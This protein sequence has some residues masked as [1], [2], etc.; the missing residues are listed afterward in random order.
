MTGYSSLAKER[1]S[2]RI[3]L[4]LVPTPSSPF[5][6]RP[7]SEVRPEIIIYDS[8]ILKRRSDL[9]GQ[10]S[11]GLPVQD[12]CSHQVQW[13]AKTHSKSKPLEQVYPHPLVHDAQSRNSQVGPPSRILD[14]ETRHPGCLSA[15]TG[16]PEVETVP[17]LLLLE[18]SLFLQR[19]TLRTYLGPIR[20]H[21]ADGTPFR[22]SEAGKPLGHRLPRR[23]GHLVILGSQ[24][25]GLC[26][27]CLPN[28]PTPGIHPEPREISS[29]PHSGFGLA[30]R[31][32]DNPRTYNGPSSLIC[33]ETIHSGLPTVLSCP[34][35]QKTIGD[36]A[37]TH[38]ICLPDPD[39]RQTELS[40]L[41]QD[42]SPKLG[43][44]QGPTTTVP[45][46]VTENPCLADMERQF[47]LP[48]ASL[49]SATIPPLD[50]RFQLVVWR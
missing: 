21:N 24:L 32:I 17:S 14:D 30:R 50:G 49:F 7:L 9:R 16:Y 44:V 18:P 48:L 5:L 46:R 40:S 10:T 6:A 29:G 36:Y 15:C 22:A 25:S 2:E 39:V 4:A 35:L 8:Q 42:N 31:K 45:C 34:R 27:I 12:L 28:S 19:P 13:S 38:R 26:P 33:S 3:V 43:A 1:S 11:K 23:L 41:G 20:F 47:N 37:G